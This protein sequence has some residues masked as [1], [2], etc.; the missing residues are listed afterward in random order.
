[1]SLLDFCSSG[2]PWGTLFSALQAMVQAWQPTH[3]SKSMTIPHR[4]I[5]YPVSFFTPN[6]RL[7]TPNFLCFVNPHPRVEK[8]CLTAQAVVIHPNDLMRIHPNPLLPFPIS[9]MTLARRNGD[10]LW[11]NSIRKLTPPFVLLKRILVPFS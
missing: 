10:P 8:G 2:E 1:M 6:S 9:I 7:R 11:M 5:S 3:L 4:G